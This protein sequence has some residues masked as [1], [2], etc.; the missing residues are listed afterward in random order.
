MTMKE[1]DELTVELVA[2]R[3]LEAVRDSVAQS[4]EVD[5]ANDEPSTDHGGVGLETMLRNIIISKA[6]GRL[7]IQSTVGTVALEHRAADRYATNAITLESLDATID[8]ATAS[9]DDD[10][11][12]MIADIISN[13]LHTVSK[14]ASVEDPLGY[15]QDIHECLF[16]YLDEV[17]APPHPVTLYGEVAQSEL[18]S[19]G[20]DDSDVVQVAT[21]YA[22]KCLSHMSG[23]ID[24]ETREAVVYVV[25]EF[26]DF[27]KGD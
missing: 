4:D 20:G 9:V 22:V 8:S 21:D 6:N 10:L 3:D 19:M 7:G 14:S 11:R 5:K 18:L 17:D 1:A 12:T 27:C 23:V 16:C 13:L 24:S 15:Q 2:I 25:G 26:Q